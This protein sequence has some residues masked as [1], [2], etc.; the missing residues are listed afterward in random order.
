M[1][2]TL[3]NKSTGVLTTEIDEAN[4]DFYSKTLTGAVKQRPIEERALQVVNGTV[5]EALGKLYVEKKFPAEAKEKAKE[6]IDY[7]FLAFENRINNLH[8]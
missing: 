4:W 2:W 5:G 7:V 8:G 6:M 1:R 3:I